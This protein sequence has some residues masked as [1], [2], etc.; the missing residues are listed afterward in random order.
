MPKKILFESAI[1]QFLSSARDIAETEKLLSP[2]NYQR[3]SEFILSMRFT[4][5]KKGIVLV[6][7]MKPST[8]S[9]SFSIEHV[10]FYTR[11]DNE[12]SVQHQKLSGMLFANDTVQK[13]NLEYFRSA[14]ITI[15]AKA[16][17]T[18]TNISFDDTE[19][20]LHSEEQFHDEW[21]SSED[22]FKINVR[23]MN[24]ACTAPEMRYIRQVLGNLKGKTLLDIGCG[25]GEASV[26][27]ALE[28]ADVTATDLSQKMLDVA[29][30]LAEINGTNIMIHKSAAENIALSK[31]QQFDIVYVGNL[32]HH[33]D[34]ESTVKN[35]LKHLK[36]DGVLVSWDPVAYNPIINIY[37]KRAMQVRTIDE[38]P[39]CLKDVRLF[40]KY[41]YNVKTRWFWL[42]A[43]SIFVLMAFVQRRDPNKERYW[44]KVVEEADKWSW[45]YKPLEL[46]DRGLLAVVPFL[47]PLCWNVVIVARHPKSNSKS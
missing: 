3:W 34:I 6:E 38:H 13:R 4:Y 31:D 17:I 43:L 30:Q 23:Q 14:V 24:E 20:R 46:V 39:L 10:P 1:H 45:L 28:G 21:A 35:I 19:H 26:Y 2:Q 42:T 44:K 32:F 16:G 22:I 27:F 37:R 15:A 47:R 8:G 12:E 33:V 7:W 9:F 29:K 5:P 40:N 36:P 25:L 41:F 18:L 11:G